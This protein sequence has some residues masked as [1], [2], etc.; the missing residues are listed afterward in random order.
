MDDALREAMVFSPDPEVLAATRNIM[1]QRRY[2]RDSGVRDDQGIASDDSR[3]RASTAGSSPGTGASNLGHGDAN[4]NLAGPSRPISAIPEEDTPTKPSTNPSADLPSAENAVVIAVPD[5][6]AGAHHRRRRRL[7]D[8]SPFA[9]SVGGCDGNLPP[10]DPLL[11]DAFAAIILALFTVGV[12]ACAV[13]FPI[14][15]ARDADASERRWEV[16]LARWSAARAHPGV[17]RLAGP[18][19]SSA[20][21]GVGAFFPEDVAADFDF[22]GD[23]DAE[24]VPVEGPEGSSDAA[25]AAAAAAAAVDAPAPLGA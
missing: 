13:A 22:T 17:P 15:G 18:Y 4:R 3:A 23:E 7:R 1:R 14:Q 12:V 21:A 8:G 11:V 20:G 10:H 2:L 6:S 19:D 9:D 25:A 24:D 5:H 16:T